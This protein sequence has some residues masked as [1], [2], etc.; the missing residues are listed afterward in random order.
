MTSPTEHEIRIAALERQCAVLA[1]QVDRL[2]V[3]VVAV[4]RWEANDK[5]ATRNALRVVLANYDAA[6]AQL[7]KRA[8]EG[9][10]RKS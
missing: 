3:V 7:A 6:M 8:G 2:Y 9:G 1:A 4:R 5:A 10:W